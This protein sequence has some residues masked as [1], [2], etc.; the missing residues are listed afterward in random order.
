M[1]SKIIIVFDLKNVLTNVPMNTLIIF[2]TGWWWTYYI[3]ESYWR[4]LSQLLRTT[5]SP[6]QLLFYYTVNSIT[7]VINHIL[8]SICLFSSSKT[9][10]THTDFEYQPIAL[11]WT[12]AYYC[13]KC[14]YLLLISQFLTYDHH[15]DIL[16]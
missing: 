2:I 9:Y 8:L 6:Y 3:Y 11:S 15:L 4:V 1:L 7:F 12:L 13:F 14:L 16:L 5:I 10:K